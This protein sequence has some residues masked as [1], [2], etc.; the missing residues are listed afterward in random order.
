MSLLKVSDSN[1]FNVAK[2]PLKF[3]FPAISKY[4]IRLSTTCMLRWNRSS[5]S[6][7]YLTETL[8]LLGQQ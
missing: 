6:I 4:N 7:F 8:Y 2:Q 3:M 5:T 1:Y